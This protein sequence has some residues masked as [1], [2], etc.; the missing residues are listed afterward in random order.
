MPDATILLG[1]A[2]AGFVQG[3]SGFALGL[4]ATAFWAATLPPQVTA[5]LIVLCS[6]A[7]QLLTIRASLPGLDLRRAAP[8]IIAG[9]A[10][11]PVG[12]A[13]LPLIDPARFSIGVGLL[14]CAW[15]PAML[16]SRS[17]PTVHLR[18]VRANR[19]ADAVAGAIG[20]LMGGLAGLSG[21]APTLWCTLRGGARD[22][23]R[24]TIQ[25]F[26]LAVQF[27]GLVAYAATGFLTPAVWR[28]AAWTVPCVLLPALCG[29][30]VYRRMNS[31][32]FR[33]M[34][35]ALL[36]LTGLL[37]VVRGLQPLR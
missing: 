26:L 30:M 10:G 5:P 16:F 14:L 4:V 31:D 18:S 21:P 19:A 3:I 29:A 34:V 9:V 22:E 35:L 17:L 20:G 28:L 27:V 11:V 24:A 32:T 33:R 15:C 23:Q 8:M 6:I 25:A 37:L 2:L 1:A 13:L 7:G 12:I 36:A